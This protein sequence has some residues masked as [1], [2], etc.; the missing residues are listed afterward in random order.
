M[1]I[2]S[3]GV[4]QVWTKGGWLDVAAK[5][6]APTDATAAAISKVAALVEEYKLVAAQA[7]HRKGDTP[8]PEPEPTPEPTPE[9]NGDAATS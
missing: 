9:P 6:I 8:D 7:K 5:D 3:N 4:F 1:H 2:G